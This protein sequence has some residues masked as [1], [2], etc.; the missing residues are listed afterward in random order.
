VFQQPAGADFAAKLL[1][2]GEVQFDAP[3]W[4]WAT[5]SSARTA[6]VKVEKSHL[7]TAAARP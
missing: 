7:L 4:A 2:V 6:K 5:A 3:A 1:V